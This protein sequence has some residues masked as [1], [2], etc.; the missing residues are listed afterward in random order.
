[1]RL[2]NIDSVTPDMKLGESIHGAAG[3]IL[4]HRGVTLTHRY[5]AHLRSIGYPAIYVDDD[6]TSDI[7]VAH[8]I[9]PETRSKV[10]RNLTEAFDAVSRATDSFRASSMTVALEHVQSQRFSRAVQAIARD[11]GLNRIFADVD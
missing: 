4:L 9:S 3:Q 6:D 7:A 8:A 10:L 2:V 1:M 11:E 5:I